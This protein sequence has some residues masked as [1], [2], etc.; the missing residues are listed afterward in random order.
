MHGGWGA[1]ELRLRDGGLTEI[2]DAGP[3][4]W[5]TPRFLIEVADSP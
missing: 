2:E 1:F 3:A 4:L 5:T